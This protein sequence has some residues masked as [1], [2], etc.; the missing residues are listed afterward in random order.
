M[1]ELRPFIRASNAIYDPFR[2]FEKSFFNNFF[3]DQK[4]LAEFKTDIQDMGENYLIEADLPGFNK[5]DIHV[6]LNGD[7]MTISAERRS[8][9]EDKDSKGGYIRCERS[10]GSFT[11]SFDVSDVKTDAIK[12]EYT[13]GVLKLTMPKKQPPTLESRRLEIE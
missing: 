2:D 9:F 8:N 7:M 1:L 5:E 6:D 10:Y 11:R 12:A 4:V 3:K 13:D